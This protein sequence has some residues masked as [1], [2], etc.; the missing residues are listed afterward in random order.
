VR[1]PRAYIEPGFQINGGRCHRS[2]ADQQPGP[3]FAGDGVGVGVDA[4]GCG[5]FDEA[6]F[7]VL[8][9]PGLDDRRVDGFG[10]IEDLYPGAVLGDGGGGD[11][12]SRSE[13]AA[14]NNRI[15]FLALR[16]F[17]AFGIVALSVYG[18]FGT[19]WALRDASRSA[20]FDAA[21]ACAAPAGDCLAWTPQTVTGVDVPERGVPTIYLSG[22][23]QLSYPDNTWVNSLTTGTV[24][25]VLEWEGDA[26]ALR[27]P[28][29]V[30]VYSPNSAPLAIYQDVAT[31]VIAFS[32][33]VL[34]GAALLGMSR[35][36]LSRPRLTVVAVLLAILGV[37]GFVASTVIG[38]ATSFAAGIITG[39]V[40]YLSIAVAVLT[41]IAIWRTRRRQ[42]AERLRAHLS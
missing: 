2:N 8:V 38:Q 37:S 27:Q 5:V 32:I 31:A 13:H 30:A 11:Q 35:L 33:A 20:A 12:L 15:G 34:V 39:L 28:D 42:R 1:D 22:G 29:G 21:P 6:P 36:R 18:A 23:Q 19:I 25:P 40:V 26:E 4:E 10:L 9:D 14:R 41:G 17:L 24:V 16:V 3:G 7:D